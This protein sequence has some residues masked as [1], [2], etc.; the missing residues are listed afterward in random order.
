MP[1]VTSRREDAMKA[2]YRLHSRSGVLSYCVRHNNSRGQ[3]LV[4]YVLIIVV[5]SILLIAA[6][7]LFQSKIN[8]VYVSAAS[9]IPP[10]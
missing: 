3:T 1:L 6:M 4:E 2:D 9:S 8:S 7:Q 10:P 5:I